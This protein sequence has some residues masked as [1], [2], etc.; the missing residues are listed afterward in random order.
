MRALRIIIAGMVLAVIGAGVTAAVL[1]TTRSG[2]FAREAAALQTRWGLEAGEGVPAAA[3]D[4]LRQ[5]LQASR[6]RGASW[7]AP[8]WWTETGQG[9]IDS[10]EQ[11]SDAVWTAAMASA[12]QQAERPITAWE[13]LQAQLGAFVPSAAATEAAAWPR[14]ARD[15]TTPQALVV[16]TTKWTQ[17]VA[18]ARTQAVAAQ[19]DAQVAELGGVKGV[20]RQAQ[21]AVDTARRINLDDAGIAALVTTLRSQIAAEQD[22]TATLA[23]LVDALGTF[24][25]L[26]ALN[27]NVAGTLRPVLLAVDQ[28]VAERTPNA[29]TYLQQYNNVSSAL[30]AA[31]VSNELTAV[32]QQLST[33]QANV[34]AELANSQCGHAVPSGKAITVAL[35]VQE[36]VFYQDG[37]VVKA[38]PVTTGRAQLRTPTGTFH[39]FFKQTPFQFIS[40]WPKESPY[41]YYPSWVSWVMEFA[42][43]GYF[44]HD[45]PWEPNWQYGPGSEDSSGASHGCIH[46]P[47]DVMRWLYTWTPMG[48]PVIITG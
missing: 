11:R 24:H 8:V 39:V 4:P 45:A 21:N 13:Q 46:I 22:A 26:L 40:P 23:K 37:C 44:L 7:W 30:I 47:T 16:L 32:A 33:L 3:F 29:S 17:S 27:N 25:Q 19:L 35:G 14:Q 5:E 9:L 28:A 12:R 42:G 6:Y 20:L 15:A 1:G 18:E 38:T 36:A 31:R 34:T 2:A 43:G 41:Y 48:T 10:L